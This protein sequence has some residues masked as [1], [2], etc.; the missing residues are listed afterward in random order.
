[1]V[2]WARTVQAWNLHQEAATKS[3]GAK[4]Y[5]FKPFQG[6]KVNINR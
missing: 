1:M 6:L 2:R 5:Q 3:L 4:L